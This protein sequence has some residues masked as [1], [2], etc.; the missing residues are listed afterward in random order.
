MCQA[1]NVTF[2]KFLINFT[3]FKSLHSNVINN[4]SSNVNSSL[5]KCANLL[6]PKNFFCTNNCNTNSFLNL[7]IFYQNV[8]GLRSKFDLVKANF[9]VFGD[10]DVVILS[11]TWLIPDIT[12]S[13]LGFC[14]FS[15]FKLDRNSATSIF[16]QG[17]G[18]L[19]A[20]RSNLSPSLININTHNVEQIFVAANISSRRFIFCAI[21]LP[22][23]YPL[24]LYESHVSVVDEVISLHSPHSFILVGDYNLPNIDWSFDN[25]GLVATGVSS[26]SL[27]LIVDSISLHNFFQCNYV[28]NSFCGVLDLVFSSSNNV[29]TYNATSPLV[30]A[31]LY[32]PLLAICY[33]ISK[34]TKTPNSIS[35]R[36]FKEANYLNINKF[37]LSFNWNDSFSLYNANDSAT[38]FNDALLHCINSYVP[39]KTYTTSSFPRWVSKEL[40]NLIYKKKSGSLF[41]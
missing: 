5:G 29:S 34:I 14:N 25:L 6:K 21:Y 30:P 9:P 31:D 26:P 22:P 4:D 35:Y 23:Y 41:I 10:Y 36:D 1:T 8:R 2:D 3:N 37:L 38:I 12:N 32:H 19:I 40:K 33:P 16:S 39:L 13:E 7:N 24:Q 27:S 11:E 17:G 18:V 28:Q 15:V 20:I